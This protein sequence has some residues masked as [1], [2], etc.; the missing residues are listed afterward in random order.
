MHACVLIARLATV[1][2]IETERSY[3]RN[4][5]ELGLLALSPVWNR[6]CSEKPVRGYATRERPEI[7]QN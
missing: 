3:D 6:A 7:Q 1:G 4:P 2:N 5:L